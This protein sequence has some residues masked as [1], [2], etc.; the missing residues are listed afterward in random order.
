MIVNLFLR[1]KMKLKL[2]FLLLTTSCSSI[3]SKLEN[4]V[5]KHEKKIERDESLKPTFCQ[6]QGQR[7]Q[8][9]S[10]SPTLDQI[11]KQTLKKPSGLSL[12]FIDKLILIHLIEMN[13]R[14]DQSSPSAR[15]QIALDLN[16]KTYFYDFYSQKGDG[17]YTYLYGL[18]YLL[19]KFKP[20]RRLEYYLPWL[21]QIPQ[22]AFTV[23]KTFEDFLI[24]NQEKI[25]ENPVLAKHYMRGTEF[26]KEEETMPKINFEHLFQE[27]R[28]Q[29]NLETVNKESKL[30]QSTQNDTNINC[31]YDMSFYQNSIFLIDKKIPESNLFG[32]LEKKNAFISSSTQNL[33]VVKTSEY[34]PYI[35]GDSYSRSSAVCLING[36][37][38]KIWLFSNQSR[39]PGQHL[40]HLLKYGLDAQTNV[41]SVDQLLR[42]SRHQFL[43]DPLRLIIES[44]RSDEDQIENLLKI[45]LPIYHSQNLG[46]IW[47]YTKFSESQHFIIDVRNTGVLVC[48]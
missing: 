6:Q 45:N 31:N 3:V 27:F 8:F 36:N 47:A 40:H 11:F 39:D 19:K 9:I 5:V 48:Q 30:I 26:L 29:K 32:Y 34:E 18:D 38:K 44:Q 21:N 42:H 1:L 25:K 14:P 23:S 35:L 17:H 15:L 24:K 43:S 16:D 37:Q 22:N 7:Y 12:D 41:Y 13:I 33:D 46:N 28:K 2:F 20:E 4:P 10:D